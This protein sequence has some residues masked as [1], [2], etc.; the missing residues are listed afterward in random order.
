[1]LSDEKIRSMVAERTLEPEV[2]A[3]L[4]MRR[5]RDRKRERNSAILVGAM[6]GAFVGIL[7]GGHWHHPTLG[8]IVGLVGG[9]IV[10]LAPTKGS[11]GES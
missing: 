8:M 1:M 5:R 7:T 6:G 9:G 2:A 10:G 4:L 3:E 11:G